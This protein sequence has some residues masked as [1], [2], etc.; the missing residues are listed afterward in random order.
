MIPVFIDTREQRPWTFPEPTFTVEKRTLRTGDYTIAGLE[1]CV[2]LE[3]KSLGDFVD[4]VIHDWIRFRKELRRMAGFDYAAVVVEADISDVAEKRYDTQANP[5]SIFGRA[6]DITIDHGIPVLWWGSRSLC[7][8]RVW[9][10]LRI[11]AKR[12]GIK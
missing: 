12:E 3:R 11:L 7:E 6:A 2:T 9:Q 4:T 5:E 8:P 10:F 1:D